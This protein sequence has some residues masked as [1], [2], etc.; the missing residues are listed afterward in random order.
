M[1]REPVRTVGGAAEF[2]PF[3]G[4]AYCAAVIQRS[5]RTVRSGDGDDLIAAVFPPN[6]GGT[7]RTKLQR[8]AGRYRKIRAA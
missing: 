8:A 1:R 7:V 5:D 6:C 4:I 2:E 3:H